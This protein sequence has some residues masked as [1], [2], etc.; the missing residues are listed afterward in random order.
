MLEYVHR[1]I[2]C[3]IDYRRLDAIE[4]ICDGCSLQGLISV[5]EI[6]GIQHD[7]HGLKLGAERGSYFKLEKMLL[8]GQ[9]SSEKQ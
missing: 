9:T 6:A 1:P 8:N 7:L 2:W 4:D 5:C 3:R